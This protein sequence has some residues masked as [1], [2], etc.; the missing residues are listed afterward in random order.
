[1]SEPKATT[2]SRAPIV[3]IVLCEFGGDENARQREI[4]RPEKW[5]LFSGDTC[6][7]TGYKLHDASQVLLDMNAT[8]DA[9]RLVVDVGKIEQ[10]SLLSLFRFCVADSCC[11]HEN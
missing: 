9:L 5:F 2:T 10:R 1:M 7:S 8:D 4:V 11:G 6:A 3:R